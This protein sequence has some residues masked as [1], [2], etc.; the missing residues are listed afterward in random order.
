[1]E[2]L[3]DEDDESP[4]LVSLSKETDS[5]EKS[6]SVD[7]DKFVT[8][9]TTTESLSLDE[10]ST[11]K[12]NPKR[13]NIPTENASNT[14]SPVTR[15]YQPPTSRNKSSKNRQP[16]RRGKKIMLPIFITLIALAAIALILREYRLRLTSNNEP[17]EISLSQPVIELPTPNNTSQRP[18]NPLDEKLD[19]KKALKIINQWL[20]AKKQAT[21]PDYNVTPL[22]KI[23][24][25]PQLSYWIGN[26][27]SLRDNNA[28]RRY[29]H[30]VKILSA[31]IN[32]QNNTQGK[33]KAKI[34]EKS[35]F[36]VNGALRSNSS[37][38]DN[39]IVEYQILKQGNQWLI[40][41]TTI[42]QNN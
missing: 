11:P 4:D 12:I 25:G 2:E 10:I 22:N 14:H 1:M 28:H 34:Q 20:E 31:E 36:Y 38:E 3:I 24:T 8:T 23:L 15:E 41:K 29:E 6:E 18:A 17:L 19:N 39:L 42:L 40:S 26:S 13:Q 21:G 16:E 30:Q 32:P 35:Q 5:Q 7:V 33:I 9:N 37:Y 27:E